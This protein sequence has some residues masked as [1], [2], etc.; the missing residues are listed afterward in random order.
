L[1][2]ALDVS[3]QAVWKRLSKAGLDTESGA[4]GYGL[5]CLS[6]DFRADLE[7]AWRA[8][9]AERLAQ[10]W[11]CLEHFISD[12]PE[13]AKAAGARRAVG[14]AA[15]AAQST[16]A[17]VDFCAELETL[18]A[19]VGEGRELSFAERE[20][21]RDGV[22]VAL[23]RA[24][25]HGWK[26]ARAKGAARA[27]L[28][29]RLPQWQPSA[30][31]LERMLARWHQGGR[32]VAAVVDN[33]TAA[34][35]QRRFVLS[36][37]DRKVILAVAMT[38]KRG[39]EA[40]W[41][42]AYASG[43]LS[44]ET[45][46][47]GY[48]TARAPRKVRETLAA[49]LIETMREH[50]E[51]PHHASNNNASYERDWSGVAAGD[52]FTIDDATLEIYTWM[53]DAETGLPVVGADGRAKLIRPQ[54]F[55]VMDCRSRQLLAFTLDWA[56][57][58][59]ASAPRGA[60]LTAFRHCGQPE[61]GVL[62]ERGI[63]QK[64]KLLGGQVIL[65]GEMQNFAGRLGISFRHAL[66]GRARTKPVEGF[67]AQ[68]QPL[69]HDVPGWCG[70][71]EMLRRDE[72][73]HDA[74][75]LV[76]RGEH[77]AKAGFL[78]INELHEVIHAKA[79]LYGRTEQNSRMMG[80]DRV[81][82]MSPDR[83]WQALQRRNE[84]GEE[85]GLVRLSADADAKLYSHRE[86]RLVT[87]NGIEMFGNRYMGEQIVWLRGQTLAVSYDE[88]NPQC[89]FVEADGQQ[90]RVDRAEKLPAMDATKDD[91]QRAGKTVGAYNR[92]TRA[93]CS[94][95]KREFMPKAR[96]LV[97]GPELAKI[98]AEGRQMLED[99]E[100]ARTAGKSSALD[101]RA[102]DPAELSE[103]V[104]GESRAYPG[105]WRLC[106]QRKELEEERETAVDI[107]L[108]KEARERLAEA[109]MTEEDLE[110]RER[111]RATEW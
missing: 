9:E 91:F 77:P 33:R 36:E 93:L 49:E 13:S 41:K 92:A 27:W 42:E 44:A 19:T 109:V 105:G 100:R 111:M 67:L 87:R 53:R 20:T 34:N 62:M 22:A 37:A 107:T 64:A 4:D 101:L 70:S 110:L 35:G 103:A 71:N 74:K 75:L 30:R 54:F 23:D 51:R 81:V 69:L 98:E 57:A 1:A 59:V 73:N 60:L 95:I 39:L 15:A 58:P 2:K 31:T 6:A 8:A 38:Q 85:I 68:F 3:R 102:F 97:S 16:G 55:P 29:Q 52:W 28:A 25:S 90:I 108:A 76:A 99:R 32:T 43:K 46:A 65:Y 10:P 63:F 5:A 94:E 14:A 78:E 82:R 88:Q 40:A 50:L 86:M 11:R 17:F 84:A 21:V 89:I 24:E 106:Q 48:S 83:A 56:T 18:L 72:G 104:P 96:S 26:L 12:P 61:R 47:R 7:Q 79:A 80:G 66:P 45:M